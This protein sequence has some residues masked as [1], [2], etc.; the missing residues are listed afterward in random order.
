[1][2][3]LKVQNPVVSIRSAPP[4]LNQSCYG[5]LLSGCHEDDKNGV[6]KIPP[7][8]NQIYNM[9]LYF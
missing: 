9:V 7:I 2:V 3:S 1:M 6:T 5:L 4:S 8:F